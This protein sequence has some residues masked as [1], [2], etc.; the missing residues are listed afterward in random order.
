MLD[1]PDIT[2]CT[3]GIPFKNLKLHYTALLSPNTASRHV[4]LFHEGQLATGNDS[5]THADIPQSSNSLVFSRTCWKVQS[6]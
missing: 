3:P 4:I 2:V 5:V 6:R 1:M